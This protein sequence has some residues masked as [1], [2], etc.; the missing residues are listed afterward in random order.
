[1][2]CK[3]QSHIHTLLLFLPT[4]TVGFF[5][6]L[7]SRITTKLS[8]KK[9]NKRGTT[10]TTH[11]PATSGLPFVIVIVGSQ[12]DRIEA[13]HVGGVVDFAVFA[14]VVVVVVVVRSFGNVD[15]FCDALQFVF[16]QWRRLI[17]VASAAVAFC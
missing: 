13:R 12:F 9:E 5:R 17:I 3:Q 10:N 4:Y 15:V 7:E 1:M 16:A 2:E 11:F 6:S 14:F 8:S